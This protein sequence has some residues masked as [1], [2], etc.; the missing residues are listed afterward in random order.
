MAKTH[1]NQLDM[2]EY[3][4][5]GFLLVLQVEGMQF[6]HVMV[7]E[8]LLHFLSSVLHHIVHYILTILMAKKLYNQ[9]DMVEYYMLE[10]LLILLVK[11]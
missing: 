4:M 5:L 8:L 10:F 7:L 11:L 9:L 6:L 3:Y 1:Y 2:I